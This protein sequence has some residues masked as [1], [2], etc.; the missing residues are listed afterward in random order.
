[1]VNKYLPINYSHQIQGKILSGLFFA[2]I[3]IL[4]LL[5]VLIIVF[6]VEIYLIIIFIITSILSILFVSFTGLIIDLYNPKLDWSRE[7]SAVK[8]NINV[9]LSFIPV[10]LISG[11]VAFIA[12][13][14]NITFY[15]LVLLIIILFLLFDWI[16]YKILMDQGIELY[17]KI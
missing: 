5:S 7:Q 8:Q 9:V 12:F 15:W 10:L 1:M 3:N 13:I 14:F 2:A 4:I 6:K 17:G 11:L 16:L